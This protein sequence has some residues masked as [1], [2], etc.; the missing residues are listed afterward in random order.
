MTVLHNAR[1]ARARILG[2]G[3]RGFSSLDRMVEAAR[4]QRARCTA[5][6]VDAA[7]V[8][9]VPGEDGR[10]VGLEAPGGLEV[11]GATPWA[12]RQLGGYAGVPA[13][14][15]ER[16]TPATAARALNETWDRQAGPVQVLTEGGEGGATLRAVTGP[17]YTRLWDADVLGEAARWLV[18]AGWVPAF[19]T[20][21]HGGKDE[22]DRERAL[23]RSDR[24][25]FAFLM[26]D[27]GGGGGV[28]QDDGLGGLRRGVFLGN[29]EV[30]ARSFVWGT[31]LF[32]DVCANFLIWDPSQVEIRRRRHTSGVLR[33]A[34]DV[35]RWMRE[36]V[37]G[38]LVD[39]PGIHV[40]NRTPYPVPAPAAGDPVGEESW[41]ERFAR[42]VSRRLRDVPLSVARAAAPRAASGDAGARPGTWWAAVNGLTAAARELT[43]AD[44]FEVGAAAGLL[45][46]QGLAAVGG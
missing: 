31:F 46:E 23:W 44:R 4:A 25:S 42:S 22:G 11:K 29:S 16:L 1:D 21:N 41:E 40:L 7:A 12:L 26:S 32:R 10:G 34:H 2:H 27:G 28:P 37:P 19:P 43:P 6:E 35:R 15:L 8:L 3:G 17:G 36:Q 38:V 45:V 24:D 18:P 30:G 39:V 9:F 14:V 20:I 13:S 5:V 33:V